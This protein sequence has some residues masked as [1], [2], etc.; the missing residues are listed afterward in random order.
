M[1]SY[2]EITSH[3][4]KLPKEEK[5]QKLLFLLEKLAISGNLFD[6]LYSVSQEIEVDEEVLNMIFRVVSKQLF[7]MND[8]KRRL[9]FNRLDS[10]KDKILEIKENEKKDL[11]DIE[12]ILDQI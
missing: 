10:I 12:A 5:R 8:E 6:K 7:V 9:A 2:D 11:E 1:L 3:F 4:A